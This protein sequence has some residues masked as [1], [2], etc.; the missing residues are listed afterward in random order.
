MAHGN[1]DPHQRIW[2]ALTPRSEWLVRRTRL[3]L[4]GSSGAS[5]LFENGAL[6]ADIFEHL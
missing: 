5:P 6:I 3:I 4:V 1:F 2:D